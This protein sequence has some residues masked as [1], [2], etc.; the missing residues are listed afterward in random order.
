MPKIAPSPQAMPLPPLSGEAESGKQKGINSVVKGFGLLTCLVAHRALGLKEL[1]QLAGLSAAQAHGY[2]IS[3]KQVNVV[4]QDEETGKYRLGQFALELGLARMRAIEPLE[5]GFAQARALADETNYMVIVTVFSTSNPVVVRVIN[6]PWDFL[7]ASRVGHVPSIVDTCTGRIF[8]AFMAPTQIE[9]LI[10]QEFKRL[11]I[12]GLPTAYSNED[13]Q[14]EL[15]EIRKMGYAH[16]VG[17]PNRFLSSLSAPVFNRN[18]QIEYVLTMTAAGKRISTG[19]ESEDVR[20]LMSVTQTL[21]AE[22]GYGVDGT[23]RNG[24]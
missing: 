15:Q 6:P 18:G 12:S 4:E 17:S 3:L 22:L 21:S 24:K 16:A 13:L 19:P 11:E 20:R 9:P 5:R 23:E 1:S 8:A 7:V 14:A 10:K 2:L